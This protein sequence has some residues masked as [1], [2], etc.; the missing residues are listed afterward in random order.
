MLEILVVGY[1][2]DHTLFGK[3]SAYKYQLFSRLNPGKKMKSPYFHTLYL[4]IWTVF[5]PQSSYLQHTL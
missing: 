1:R 5:L 4:E 2:K 3:A